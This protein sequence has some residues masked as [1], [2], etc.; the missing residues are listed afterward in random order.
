MIPCENNGI[1]KIKK[2]SH[3]QQDEKARG[4]T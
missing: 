2:A 3:P 4:T 1:Y